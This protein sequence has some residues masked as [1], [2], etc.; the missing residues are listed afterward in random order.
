MKKHLN[1][2]GPITKPAGHNNPNDRYWPS[3]GALDNS[4]IPHTPTYWTCGIQVFFHYAPVY[5][6]Q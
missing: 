6:A 2:T 4:F 5:E 3:V 1:P